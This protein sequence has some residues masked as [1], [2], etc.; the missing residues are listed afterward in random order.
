[1][2][3]TRRQLNQILALASIATILPLSDKSEAAEYV[4]GSTLNLLV[5]PEPP[6]LVTLAHTA[7]PTTRVSGKVTEGLLAYA[8]DFTPIPQLAT[9]WE[10]SDDGLAYAPPSPA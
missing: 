7:G 4:A 9:A 1:M 2:D 5:Q 8:L 3:I 6:T 10:V